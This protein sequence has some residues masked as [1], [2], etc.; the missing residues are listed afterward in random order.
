MLAGI[1]LR[2][3]A[4]AFSS[5]PSAPVLVGSMLTAFL[6]A[7]R[8]TPKF[9]S[10]LVLLCGLVVAMA[11][12]LTVFSDVTLTLAHPVFTYPTFSVSAI[13]G[14]ALP[15]F[16]VTLASQ[17]M[18]GLAVLKAHGYDA[19]PKMILGWTGLVGV[20]L[21]PF[22]AFS[23]N[24]AAITAALCMGQDVDPDSARRYRATV[25][26]GG[27]YILTGVFGATVAALLGALP[28]VLIVAFTG[29]ALVGTLT[30]NLKSALDGKA[31]ELN[32]A[33]ITFAITTSGLALFG[34]GSTLWGLL[35][36]VLLSRRSP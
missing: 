8:W 31:H 35:V 6:I 22:G 12:G 5:L 26:A 27:F 21:A 1:V 24:I 10:L 7:R 23:I 25:W 4:S 32:A 16:I 19:P 15:L 17:N 30:A 3:V 29:I 9:A 33:V 2:F 18:A 36:G 14:V 34:V 28:G 20:L 11:G 13:L